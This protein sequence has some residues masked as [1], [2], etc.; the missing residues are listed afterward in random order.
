MK[1]EPTK[2]KRFLSPEVLEETLE[3][4][5]VEGD[6][7]VVVGGLAM[8]S[9]GSDRLTGDL[10]LL[11]E[12]VPVMVHKFK[13][14]YL[15]FGG[16]RFVMNG[17]PVDIIVRNDDLRA[18]Y[19]DAYEKALDET[20]TRV[21]SLEHLAVMKM[22]AGR[23]KDMLDLEFLLTHPR[24]NYASIKALAVRFLGWYAGKE[25]DV[26]RSEAEWKKKSGLS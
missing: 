22:A 9:Y 11:A 21:V 20:T 13:A 15:S 26:L 8:Q 2:K 24:A 10:D 17:V 16:V 5:E 18:L 19:R 12:T 14:T 3:A 1:R 6:Q 25:L 7:F 4:L 23:S